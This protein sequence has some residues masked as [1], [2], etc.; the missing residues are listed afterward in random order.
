MNIGENIK[1]IR[2]SK[3]LTQYELANLIG[4][5]RSYL[6][7]IENNRKNLSTK[8]LEELAKKLEIPLNKLLNINDED[9]SINEIGMKLYHHYKKKVSKDSLEYKALTYYENSFKL[10]IIVESSIYKILSIPILNDDFEKPDDILNDIDNPIVRRVFI[11][12]FRTQYIENEKNDTNLI[13]S[14]IGKLENLIPYEDDIY[15]PGKIELQYD[16]KKGVLI[17]VLE[18]NLSLNLVDEI[19]NI[20]K[21][22]IEDIELL[23]NKYTKNV[24][25]KNIEYLFM[26][27]ENSSSPLT[28]IGSKILKDEH[29][30]SQEDYEKYLIKSLYEVVNNNKKN[31]DPNILDYLKKPEFDKIISDITYF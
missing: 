22:C 17:S 18:N 7:D 10:N 16:N 5:S 28:F 26:N 20:L 29:F 1:R 2:K 23:S 6:G 21:K 24:S 13:L 19:Q 11:E 31:L 25:E 4:I 8:T 30:K 15:Y 12:T 14:T 9:L 27:L 3:G